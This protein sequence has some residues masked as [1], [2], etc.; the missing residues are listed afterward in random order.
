MNM[1]TIRTEIEELTAFFQI[2][3][4]NEAPHP[5]VNELWDKIPE[6]IA[7]LDE[8]EVVELLSECSQ[9]EIEAL[10]P[11]FDLIID[12]VDSDDFSDFIVGLKDKFSLDVISENIDLAV[13]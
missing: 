1:K 5:K 13:S 9:D 8:D 11:I 6:D 3:K 7:Q 2:E 4:R 12:A 10:S